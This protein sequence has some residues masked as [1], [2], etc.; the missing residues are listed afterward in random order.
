[1][2]SDIT[3][4]IFDKKKHYNGVRMQQ[5]RVMLDSDWNAQHD[6]Y[7]HRQVTQTKDVIGRC[8]VPR[9][10]DSFRIVSNGGMFTISP[11]RFYIEGMLCELFEEVPYFDQPNFPDPPF[12]QDTGVGSPPSSPPNSP[13]EAPTL[14]LDDGRYMVYLK[15][16]I[17]ERTSLDDPQIQ[18]VAL[19]GADTT[20]RLQTVWQ[21]ILL[22]SEPELTCSARSQ[23]W[24]TNI[25]NSSGK[26]NARTVAA[27]TSEDPC[28]L[29]QS[30][31]Y[32]RLE[33]QL[34]R[35]QIH[36][37]GDL[38]SATY[39]WSR[40]NASIETKV[41]EIDNLT[42]RVDNT[43]KD[44]V[45]G[46]A[47]GQWVEF[48]NENT[49]L[50]QKTYELSK[51]TEVNPAKSEIVIE[52][53]DPEVNFSEGMKLRRWDSASDDKDGL[54]L[55]SG[56]ESIEDGI[57]VKFN[58]GTYKSGDYWLVPAR[59]NTAEIEWPGGDVAPFGTSFSYC[60]LAIIDLA[61]NQITS[62]QDC[63]PQFPTLTDLNDLDS[64]NCCTYHVGPGEGWEVVFDLIGNNESAKICFE[65]G[66]YNLSATKVIEKKG[67]LLL[68]GSGGGTQITG[69]QLQVALRFK[70]CNSVGISDLGV[71]TT[72]VG[73]SDPED[74][75]SL[76]GSL[77]FEGVK[78]VELDRVVVKCGHGTNPTSSAVNVFSAK[79]S[80]SRVSIRNSKFHVGYMQIGIIVI[81]TGRA[82]IENNQV[83]ILS[84]PGSLKLLNRLKDNRFRN[85]LM[86]K[87]IWN[88]SDRSSDSTN[89][90][91]THGNTNISFRTDP[92]LK[93]NRVWERL[94]NDDRPRG[95]RN[96]K[97]LK[98]Y[99]LKKVASLLLDENALKASALW[100]FINAISRQDPS[101]GY[102][103]IVVGGE[104]GE[105]IH[106]VRNDIDG[107]MQGIHI[108]LSH[109]SSREIF[110]EL[111]IVKVEKN[112]IANILSPVAS[113]GRHGIFVGHC[114]NLF[115][116]DND[117]YLKRMPMASDLNIDGIR[118]W[119]KFGQ[120]LQVSNNYV[121]GFDNPK[122]HYSV[123]IRI[124]PVEP[125]GRNTKWKIVWNTLSV[126]R[127][128]IIP[129]EVF[130]KYL[131]T[132]G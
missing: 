74:P 127:G 52:S 29:Q 69:H 42:I 43:G 35:V 112:K 4:L 101:L 72:G 57:E 111:G 105:N 125:I 30:G 34:Y 47:V 80:P 67:D 103:G 93:S 61:Q 65:V 100:D 76:K 82:L 131:D 45:L 2:P 79:A 19:G 124:V 109:Q 116:D 59:T 44:E 56:W 81:N 26:L 38:A 92:A 15:A 12:L 71:T 3:R 94:I 40:D 39:K 18:E 88:M 118:L 128:L 122:L 33:N 5:G 119:G 86:G 41:S 84:R 53:I 98:E 117:L 129:D 121:G 77:T 66:D 62:I 23:I 22:K 102:Q 78:E 87:M 10:S 14:D 123:G 13:P 106:I 63:R 55:H 36:T 49:S 60:K 104:T 58:M 107:M 110:D 99:F 48:I 9:N 51:I 113:M 24:E 31:G 16:W 126:S 75:I 46:F 17:R 1:M 20:A 132:N 27:D 50:N 37:G 89:Y 83:S 28:S 130:D 11:G 108:G 32:R 21:A 97:D 8:G 68:E 6:I 96:K 95:I 85:A 7:H 91:L 115:I 73:N 120:K 114:K 70:S 90:T 64:G 25:E 54:G